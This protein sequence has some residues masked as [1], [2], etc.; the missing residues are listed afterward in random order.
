MPTALELSPDGW[1]RYL[2]AARRRPA[3]PELT[4]DERRTRER[5]LERIREA[6]AMLKSRF[7]ARR[8]VLFGSL[9]HAAWFTPDSDV[10]LAVEGLSGDDYWQAWRAVEEIIG[11]RQVDLVE[12]ETVGESLKRSIQRHGVE[13]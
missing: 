3:P 6:A 8:V 7:H 9:A 10:D 4:P 5:L 13:L 11:D 1:K 12:I 2:E